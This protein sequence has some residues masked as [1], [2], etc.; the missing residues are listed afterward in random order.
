MGWGRESDAQGNREQGDREQ[1]GL[2]SISCHFRVD[3]IYAKQRES[4]KHDFINVR[5]T[6]NM[7]GYL[8]LLVNLGLTN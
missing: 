8:N 7:I 4:Q 2:I 1:R 6:G 3:L 5:N